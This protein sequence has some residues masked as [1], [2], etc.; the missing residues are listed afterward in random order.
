MTKMYIYLEENALG[1]LEFTRLIASPRQV[2]HYFN[3]VMFIE[4]PQAVL[5]LK[6]ILSTRLLHVELTKNRIGQVKVL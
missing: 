6:F 1:L 4:F 2:Q 3:V 5:V